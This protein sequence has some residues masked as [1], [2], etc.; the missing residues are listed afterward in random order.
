MLALPKVNPLYCRALSVG[1]WVEEEWRDNGKKRATTDG[2]NQREETVQVEA[3]AL[4]FIKSRKIANAV[5]KAM[6]FMHVHS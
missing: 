2:G 4:T 5:L 6:S 1:V 3:T